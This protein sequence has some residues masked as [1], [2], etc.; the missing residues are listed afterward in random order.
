ME[1]DCKEWL[2]SWAVLL[3][4][5][6][7]T[8]MSLSSAGKPSL[9]KRVG[10]HRVV[11]TGAGIITAMGMGWQENVTGFREGRVALREVTVFD[12]SRQRVQRAGEVEFRKPLPETAL[13]KRQISRL[14]RA[15]KLLIHAGVEALEM[16]GWTQEM[17]EEEMIPMCLGTSAGAMAVGEHYYLQ[18]VQQ[19]GK[20]QGLI[21]DVMLYQ[22]ATQGRFLADALGV[23]GSL[24]I[25]TN[26]CAS[27]A[28]AIG[29]GYRMIKKGRARRVIAGGY[30]ALAHM[31][32]AG[33]DSLQALSTT[34]A[35]PFDANRDGLALGEGAGLVTLERY[36]DA[37][38]RG[39]VILAEV[40]GYGT[41]TDL[42]HLTQPHPQG[43]AALRSM[44]MAC[45]EAGVTAREVQYINS[46]GTGTPLNDVAEGMAI[47]R[48]A[49]D[50]VS[51][52]M[53]SSTKGA[54]GHL[55]GGAGAVEAVI[56]VMALREGFVP[57][58]TTIVELDEVCTFDVVREPREVPLNCVLTN[59]FGFGGANATLILQQPE[60]QETVTA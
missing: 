2:P 51:G 16:A 44:S 26:A 41:A 37:V 11:I 35:R 31:V 12:A 13:S 54:I 3:L 56:C 38:A 42:H 22:P 39:A 59:S 48:W 9:A 6:V 46:H 40:T 14:D 4:Y 20:Q 33:F 19:P 57:P 43:D 24:T 15:S 5:E 36:E 34:S 55:L 52:V 7:L 8:P 1:G 32:F 28:N 58:T 29:D 50:E 27:G 47:Q 49:G 17:R 10:D 60:A 30:D 18:R 23:N 21:E 25:I 45:A 53:V